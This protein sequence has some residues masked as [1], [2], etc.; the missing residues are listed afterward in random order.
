MS[1]E[2]SS[3]PQMEAAVAVAGAGETVQERPSWLPEDWKFKSVVRMGGATAGVTDH[4][5]YEPLSGKRFRSKIA[6]LDFL[7]KKADSETPKGRNKEVETTF[8]F[9]SVNPPESV[10]WTLTDSNEDTWI[11]SIN[12][13]MISEMEKQQWDVVFSSVSK[14]EISNTKNDQK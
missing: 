8:F 5:Y 6:V 1:E 14:L 2:D 4:Y 10:C 9:D 12:G 13:D 11:P 7:S 3:I